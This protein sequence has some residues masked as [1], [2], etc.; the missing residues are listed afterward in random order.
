MDNQDKLFEQIKQAS[1]KEET[2]DFPAIDK[3]WSRVAEKLDA[4]EAK[5][6]IGLWKKIAVAA[7]LL[8]VLSLG[9]QF[10]K[11]EDKRIISSP[12]TVTTNADTKTNTTPIVENNSIALAEEGKIIPEKEAIR[13]LK[14]QIEKEEILV[15][16]ETMLSDTLMEN[17]SAAPIAISDDMGSGNGYFEEQEEHESGAAA[18]SKARM[19]HSTAMGYSK[20]KQYDGESSRKEMQVLQKTTPLIVMNGQALADKDTAK[21]DQL[22]QQQLSNLDPKNIESIIVLEAPLY[23]INGVYYSENDLF[24]PTPTSPYAP[25]N[26]QEIKTITVLQGEEATATYGEKGKKGVVII[27]TKTGKPVAPK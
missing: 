2:K 13:I 18:V 16:N 6:T 23:I 9:F 15:A 25:L 17:N 21:K 22:I 3:V 14:N 1:L 10:L 19:A 27:F 11:S 7:S 5:K 12:K 24:S 26:K 20:S 8:L 4:K